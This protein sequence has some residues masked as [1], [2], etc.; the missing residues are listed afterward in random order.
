MMR[1]GLQT[2]G[3]MRLAGMKN[4]DNM[5]HIEERAMTA[6]KTGAKLN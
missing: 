6:Y 5:R 4:K 3:V 1:P 2:R